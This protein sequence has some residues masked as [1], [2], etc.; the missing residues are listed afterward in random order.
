MIGL[1]IAGQVHGTSQTMWQNIENLAEQGEAYK[2]KHSL[3]KNPVNLD[4]WKKITGKA[5]LVSHVQRGQN[6]CSIKEYIDVINK[7]QSEIYPIPN[8]TEKTAVMDQSDQ[9]VLTVAPT[10]HNTAMVKYN[11]DFIWLK[12]SFLLFAA[13]AG[14][15]AG[16][17]AAK[18]A[19]YSKDLVNPMSTLGTTLRFCG[20]LSSLLLSSRGKYS[21][22][23][24]PNDN[25]LFVVQDEA[26]YAVPVSNSITIASEGVSLVQDGTSV[27]GAVEVVGRVVP[28]VSY[29]I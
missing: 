9:N 28:I 21:K 27:Y 22:F 4:E 10:W 18:S 17:N 5:S 6:S 14:L 13:G 24:C 15:L 1:M 25:K 19:G 8:S 29:T 23:D 20:F 11:L 7:N 2:V 3:N 16:A 12:N 26:V